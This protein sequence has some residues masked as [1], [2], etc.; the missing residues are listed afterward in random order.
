MLFTVFFNAMNGEA[1]TP[2]SVS[3]FFVEAAI[4]SV[5]LGV[6]VGLGEMDYVCMYVCM[7]NYS[8]GI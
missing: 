7:E 1:L 6:V 3:A 4:G 5:A 8:E 2:A